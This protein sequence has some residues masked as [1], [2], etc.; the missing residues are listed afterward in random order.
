MRNQNLEE[1]VNSI[2]DIAM[3]RLKEII[4]V[5]TVVG[6]PIK[7]NSDTTILPVSKVSVGFVAGGGEIVARAKQKLPKDPFAGG[8]GSGFV[9]NPIGFIIFDSQ[10]A[11]YINCDNKT[12]LDE[13]MK[14]SNNLVNKVVG[15]KKVVVDEK[16]N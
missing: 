16:S 6:K 4:D 13:I 3:N 8:S 14:F 15:D 12:P 2:I 5:N 7:I 10:G 11:K 9:V 1:N